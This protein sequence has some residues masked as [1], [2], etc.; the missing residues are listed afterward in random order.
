MTLIDGS[1]HSVHFRFK[2]GEK[3]DDVDDFTGWWGSDWKTKHGDK[4]KE[5]AKNWGRDKD[6]D[7]G[8]GWFR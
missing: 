6:D 2:K 3:D 5:W 4:M 8:R 1:T 7:W